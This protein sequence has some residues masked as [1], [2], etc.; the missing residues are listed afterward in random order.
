MRHADITHP[1]TG[2]T[3]HPFVATIAMEPATWAKFQR[4]F[5]DQKEV[6][7]LGVDR[8]EPDMWTVFVAC[9]SRE[10][11]DLLESNW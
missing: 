8:S 2:T 10:V 5:E 4:T 3:T 6:Q 9:A 11:R 7:Q 1:H